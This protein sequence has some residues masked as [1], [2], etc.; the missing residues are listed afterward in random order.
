VA[1]ITA[2]GEPVEVLEVDELA[3]PAAGEVLLDFAAAGIG[4]WDQLVRIGSWLRLARRSLDV[5]CNPAPGSRS[6]G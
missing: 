3:P 4:N 5:R 6:I 2:R 1:G